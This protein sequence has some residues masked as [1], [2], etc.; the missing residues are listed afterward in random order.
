MKNI[1]LFYIK[2]LLYWVVIQSFF[3]IIFVFSYPSL[4]SELGFMD[5]LRIFS[6]GLPLDLS[7]VGYIMILPTLILLLFSGFKFNILPPFFKIYTLI[8]L[9]AIIL[10]SITNIVT[11]EYWNTPIDKSIFDYLNTPGDTVSSLNTWFLIVLILICILLFYLFGFVFY[12]I[13]FNKHW[14]DYKPSWLYSLVFIIVLPA[15][16]IPI[17]GGFGMPINT[18]VGY[19]HVN[20]FANHAAINP[21]WNVFYT[22]TE[23][24][25][26]DFQF[27]ILSNTE[28]EEIIANLHYSSDGNSPA[29]V[30]PGSNVVV[31]LL[32]S[33]SQAM[34]QHW[35]GDQE[36][37]PAFNRLIPEGIFFSNFYATGTMTDRGL[38]AIISGYPA[39]SRTCIFR[40]ERKLNDLSFLTRDLESH[41]YSSTFIYGGDIDFAHIRSYMVTAGFDNI[42]TENDFSTNIKRSNWG[43]PDEYVLQRLIE[44]CDQSTQPFF[45]VCLTLSSHSPFDVPMDPVFEETSH[46]MSFYNSAFYT[47]KC[48]GEFFSQAKM[49]EWWENTL[50]VL[51]ADH[52]SRICSQVDYGQSRFHIP[53]LW[54]GGALNKTGIV[55][56]KYSSQTDFPKT[57]LNQLNINPSIEYKYSKDILDSTTA[58]F[59]QYTFP[60]GFGFVNDSTYIVYHYPTNG[61]INL[62]EFKFTQDT[63]V[64]L[65]YMQSV[66]TDFINR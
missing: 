3:R 53:M 18:G 13:L 45:N 21:V 51:L 46:K 60:Q 4:I 8:I 20:S 41:G 61:F 66:I 39:L 56:D 9:P 2:Y 19:F 42:L 22:I 57:L 25:S 35:E 59:A 15:L 37:I 58:S 44:E 14:K 63:L 26:M 27:N 55:V 7:L 50:I 33:F 62:Q 36:V 12:R 31:I 64:G 52:G 17:R 54:I 5:K 11:Y 10:L 16:I 40:Y 6:H 23:S 43:V 29:Y 48:L 28:V 1:A 24:E 47:D 34:I 32:E 30:M 49:K 38:A 65:A